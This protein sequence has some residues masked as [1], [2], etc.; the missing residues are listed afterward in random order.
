M[1]VAVRGALRVGRD[2]GVPAC[3]PGVRTPQWDADEDAL[4]VWA[5]DA[6][7]VEGPPVLVEYDV[8]FGLSEPLGFGRV[9]EVE[10]CVQ[11]SFSYSSQ[12][13]HA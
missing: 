10:A 1:A 4:D 5:D 6:A 13:P 3:V 11:S 7:V 2:S 12:V 8:A 9:A